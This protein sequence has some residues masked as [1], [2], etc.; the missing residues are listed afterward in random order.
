MTESCHTGVVGNHGKRVVKMMQQFFP[1]LI[2][3][4]L[5]KPDLVSFQRL[6]SNKQ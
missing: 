3:R 6:P 5:A 4:R 1:F 2:F